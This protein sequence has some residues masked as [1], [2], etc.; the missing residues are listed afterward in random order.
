MKALRSSPFLSPASL[1][2]VVILFCCVFFGAASGLADRQSFM[3][4][5]RSSPFFPV[6][7]LLQVVILLCCAVCAMAGELINRGAASAI[8][9]MAIISFFIIDSGSVDSKR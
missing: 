4:A 3:K 9:E 6:A 1:L 2:Q 5:L 7:S 8:E